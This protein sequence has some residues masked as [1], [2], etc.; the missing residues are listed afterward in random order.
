MVINQK[1]K[2]V[3]KQVYIPFEAPEYPKLAEISSSEEKKEN[4][5]SSSEIDLNMPAANSDLSSLPS[6]EGNAEPVSHPFAPGTPVSSNSSVGYAP[7]SP[8]FAPGTPVSSN[9]SVPFAPGSPPYAPGTPGSSNSSIPFAPGSPVSSIN[10][11]NGSVGFNPNTPPINQAITQ[12]QTTVPLN[13]NIEDAVVLKKVFEEKKKEEEDKFEPIIFEKPKVEKSILEIEDEKTESS[14]DKNE[15][16]SSSSSS[17][18]TS[19]GNKIIK[20]G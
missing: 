4:I 16:S 19:G 14:K 6:T 9:S 7:V 1:N 2:N 13:I 11:S 18:D 5:S 8:P 17:N 3:T 10:S 12:A 15:S 20:L